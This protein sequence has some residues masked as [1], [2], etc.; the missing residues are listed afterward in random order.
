MG[1]SRLS[2]VCSRDSKEKDS[3]DVTFIL[4]Y[5]STVQPSG[6]SVFDMLG[7]DNVDNSLPSWKQKVLALVDG[8]SVSIVM[9]LLTV[10]VLFLDD[11]RLACLPH[12][13]D[14]AI[15]IVTLVCLIFFAIELSMFACSTH[16]HTLLSRLEKRLSRV[17]GLVR[18]QR[19]LS[20]FI[21]SWETLL[22][23]HTNIVPHLDGDQL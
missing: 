21:A 16:L 14:D 6:E 20:G 17:A 22:R 5:H 7:V 13:A 18:P 10:L 23:F 4:L 19:L 9:T 15:V 12:S 2:D 8:V 11:T 1:A 3:P